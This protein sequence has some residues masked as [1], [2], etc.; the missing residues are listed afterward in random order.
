MER[1][2]FLARRKGLRIS[3]YIRAAALAEQPPAPR[4]PRTGRTRFAEPRSVRCEITLH[5]V[6]LKRIQHLADSLSLPLARFVREAAVGYSLRSRA[7][8]ALIRQLTRVGTNL[9]QLTRLA[10]VTQ[11]IDPGDRLQ[12][13]LD[14]I[15]LTLD[16]L[17]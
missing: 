5:P 17:L 16:E 3:S 8:S 2:R 4:A 14:R 1:L 11:Q 12:A 9:N 15:N 6:E 7:D 13:T 10:H